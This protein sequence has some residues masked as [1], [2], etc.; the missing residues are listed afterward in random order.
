MGKD[1]EKGLEEVCWERGKVDGEGGERGVLG[2]GERRGRR[3]RK[4]RQ[5]GLR[6]RRRRMERRS[7]NGNGQGKVGKEKKIGQRGVVSQ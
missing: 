7:G 3:E 5:L 6:E 4:R 1:R 2:P